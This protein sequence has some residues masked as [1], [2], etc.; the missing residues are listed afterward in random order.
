[1]MVYLIHFQSKYHHA[2]HY[3]GFVDRPERIA[4]RLAEHRAGRGNPL[5]L[6]INRAEIPWDVVRTWPRADRL[7]ERRLKLQKNAP[8]LCPI[9]NPAGWTRREANRY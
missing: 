2:Q 7:F 1:M 5:L 3:L 8:R 9:C 6:A 4:D